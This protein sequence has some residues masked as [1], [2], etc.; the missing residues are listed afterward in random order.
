VL[1]PGSGPIIRYLASD[2]EG[3]AN[4]YEFGVP[5]YHAD[6]DTPKYDVRCTKPWGTCGLQRAPVPVPD[7][8]APNE[9][10]DGVMIVIDWSTR[11]SYEF[12]QARKVGDSWVASWGD[13]IN[14][15][16]PG[17][18]SS[19]VGA[20]VSR[21]AGVV[22]THELEQGHIPHALVFSTDNACEERFREPATKTDGSSG[23]A[24]CIPE[25]ARIQLDPSIDI[26][27]IP[28]M[29]PA[30]RA[31]AEALQTYGAYAI[32]NG[33][34]KMAFSFE[35]PTGDQDPYAAVGFDHDYYAMR[36]IPW[37]RL[38]LLRQWDG[39]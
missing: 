25:G 34:T 20:G 24:D 11:R 29:T 33:G 17:Y 4:L 30:E 23:S 15:D 18:P 10:S 12:W 36:H 27:R 39:R 19:A 9:G 14:V 5:I 6:Q 21:L 37:D 16:G 2:D 1:D 7:E 31:V 32:D 3:T 26:D 28:G 13:V 22:R 8:A 38:R 35:M